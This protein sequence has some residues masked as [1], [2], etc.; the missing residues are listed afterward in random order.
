MNTTYIFRVEVKTLPKFH[1]IKADNIQEAFK[2][3]NKLFDER[4]GEGEYEIV[5]ISIDRFLTKLPEIGFEVPVTNVRAE[6]NSFKLIL[7]EKP[8]TRAFST[9]SIDR[10]QY[11]RLNRPTSGDRIK[12]NL[13]LNLAVRSVK[14][15]LASYRRTSWKPIVEDGDGPVDA[16]KFS[17]KPWLSKDMEW[18]VCPK[19]NKPMQFFVQLNLADLPK[20][21]K[22]DFGTGLL[23]M[24]YCT[25]SESDCWVDACSP[26]AK[27]V[28]AR[29]IQ[30]DGEGKDVELPEIEDPF[31]PKLI[32]GWESWDDY[33]HG[34][35]CETG[36]LD[37]HLDDDEWDILIDINYRGDKLWGWPHWVQSAGYTRCP[38]CDHQ[39]RVVFQIDSYDNLPYMFGDGDRGWITQ[40]P[41]HKE[42]LTFHFD[43]T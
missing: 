28:L 1:H 12:V 34:E 11:N 42:Q 32:T 5:E 3:A 31:P 36:E 41:E 29:I 33:P 19:C 15:K 17:G 14:E 16:S 23:Q 20:D 40:C 43:S 27:S 7:G 9:I 35:E 24:F 2:K 18:P 13:E 8:S 26:F 6:N 38:V 21:L 37:V 25:N 10:Y 4:Y 39:M 30:P 22:E